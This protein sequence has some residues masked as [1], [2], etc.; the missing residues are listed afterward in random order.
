MFMLVFGYD[1]TENCQV[2]KLGY[3]LNSHETFLRIFHHFI[4]LSDFKS[5]IQT[6]FLCTFFLFLITVYLKCTA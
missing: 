4:T 6:W 5:A 3:R 1:V 2:F